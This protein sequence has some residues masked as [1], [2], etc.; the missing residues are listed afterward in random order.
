MTAHKALVEAEYVELLQSISGDVPP[1]MRRAMTR[2][3]EERARRIAVHLA[4]RGYV[5]VEG[6]DGK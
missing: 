6:D 4:Q 1:E 5:I 3:A 2:L